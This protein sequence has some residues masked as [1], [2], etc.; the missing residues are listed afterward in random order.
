MEISDISPLGVLK[1]NSSTWW[2]GQREMVRRKGHWYSWFFPEVSP[3]C[4]MTCPPSFWNC[5]SGLTMLTVY[6][7]FFICGS[8]SELPPH[9]WKGT[10]E[11][12]E[13]DWSIW[14]EVPNGRGQNLEYHFLPHSP[15]KY[16]TPEAGTAKTFDHRMCSETLSFVPLPWENKRKQEKAGDRFL[17]RTAWCAVIGTWPWLSRGTG[18][19]NNPFTSILMKWAS[20]Q[21]VLGKPNTLP[22]GAHTWKYMAAKS[23]WLQPFTVAGRKG[24]PRSGSAYRIRQSKRGMTPT[25]QENATQGHWA[26]TILQGKFPNTVACWN[27]G[28]QP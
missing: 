28:T 3:L 8:V 1:G 21:E 27:K 18:E 5:G 25:D 7:P 24:Q 6:Y 10:A 12:V 22:C 20:F 11:P 17:W 9:N 13:Q 26:E 4:S 15:L 19:E 2:K 16:W 23:L 14:A